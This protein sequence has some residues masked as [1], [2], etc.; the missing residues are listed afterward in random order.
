V[1]DNTGTGYRAGGPRP[2]AEK[3]LLLF[4][5]RAYPE[6]AE[7]IAGCL[8]IQTTH[9][10]ASIEASRRIPAAVFPGKESLGMTGHRNGGLR[11]TRSGSA[12]QRAVRPR[13]CSGTEYVQWDRVPVQERGGGDDG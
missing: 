3:R 9:S 6:L 7:E 11:S 13:T 8:G 10:G 12:K 2:P 1:S 4:G 5:G